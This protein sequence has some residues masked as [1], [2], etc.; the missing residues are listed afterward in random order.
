MLKVSLTSL[1]LRQVVA[2]LQR[3]FLER[4]Y[5]NANHIQ[6]RGADHHM[7]YKNPSSLIKRALACVTKAV[8]PTDAVRCFRKFGLSNNNRS[9][10]ATSLQ[11]SH[12]LFQMTA[13]YYCYKGNRNL[14]SLLMNCTFWLSAEDII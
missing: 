12:T 6:I 7:I 8:Q 5:P 3:K 9:I 10:T 4:S 13:T 14:G 1:S 2:E 11:L